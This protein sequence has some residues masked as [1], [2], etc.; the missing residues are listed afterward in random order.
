MVALLAPLAFGAFGACAPTPERGVVLWHAYSGVEREALESVG[1]RWNREHPD[2]PLTLVA[3]PYDGFADKLSVAIPNGN[4]PDLF[5]YAQ[6]RLGAW[7]EARLIEPIAFWVDD[8]VADRF[9]RDALVPLAYDDELW[10]LPL[11]TKT[12][13]LY[14]RTDLVDVA[15][16][17]TDEI[18]ARA[19]AARMAGRYALAY[20]SYELYGHSAWLHAFGGRVF[21]DA[22]ELDITTAEAVRAGEF[23]RGWVAD[24]VMPL[25]I[26]GDQL[27]SLFNE[28][29]VEMVVSGPWFMGQIREGTPWAVTTLPVVSETGRAAQPYLTA[30]GVVMSARARDKDAAFAVMDALTGDDSAVVRGRD[31]RQ[32]VANRA[33]YQDLRISGDGAL[34]TFRRQSEHSVPMPATPTMREVWRPYEHALKDIL[35]G[36]DAGNAL[37]S[38][39][40]EVDE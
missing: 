11:A 25:E 28:G 33:A 34:I 38:V 5:I 31:A 13:A 35:G 20:L 36:G 10:A 3:V 39:E 22:G 21:D 24:G 2:Q 18:A 32:V 6:D 4:G 17:T 19:P 8:G 14:Y 37:R 1:A 12:L 26:N 29:K 16:R 30:E 7:A 27:G 15:P 40:R 9:D 23:V